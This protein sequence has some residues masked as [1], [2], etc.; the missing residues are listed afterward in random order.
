METTPMNPEEFKA[1]SYILIRHGLSEFNIKALIAKTEYGEGSE[2]FRAV[3]TDPNGEDP[4]LH[5]IG[6]L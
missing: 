1:C 6:V 2:E 4:D 3:E 5:E